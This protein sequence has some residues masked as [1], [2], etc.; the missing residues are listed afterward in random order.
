MNGKLI[1]ERHDSQEAPAQFGDS[2]PKTETV[3]LLRLDTEWRLDDTNTHLAREIRT[4]SED[5]AFKV[6][7][8]RVIG[9]A[10][11]IANASPATK[12]RRGL[13]RTRYANF[14]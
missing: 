10:A 1:S 2:A 3:V 7:S 11:T 6:W 12:P 5:A 13:T 8:E 14:S 4:L 9:H